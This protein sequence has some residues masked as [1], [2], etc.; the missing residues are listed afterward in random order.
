MIQQRPPT[1]K[2]TIVSL[3]IVGVMTFGTLWMLLGSFAP[4]QE[5]FIPSESGSGAVAVPTNTKLD[6]SLFQNPLFRQLTSLEGIVPIDQT[7]IGRANPF[8][9]VSQ[10]KNP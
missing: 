5:T 10:K 6:D 7:R 1:K 3:V 8:I 4:S 9:P 2:K